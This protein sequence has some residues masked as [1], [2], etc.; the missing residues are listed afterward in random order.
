M[1][2]RIHAGW[3]QPL[4]HPG[5]TPSAL[6]V[7]IFQQLWTQAPSPGLRD[8][9][10]PEPCDEWGLSTAKL[11]P[12]SKL[13]QPQLES[14][15][16]SSLGQTTRSEKAFHIWTTFLVK[17]TKTREKPRSVNSSENS[18]MSSTA[19]LQSAQGFPLFR[20]GKRDNRRSSLQLEHLSTGSIL[21]AGSPFRKTLSVRDQLW[22]L[23]Q[24][25]FLCGTCSSGSLVAAAGEMASSL[26]GWAAWSLPHCPGHVYLSHCCTSQSIPNDICF[27]RRWNA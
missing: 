23:L 25:C 14:P 11:V 17:D 16:H 4:A 12:D 7:H 22:P 19:S 18:S 2:I 10:G 21:E 1:S 15:A 5:K 20:E 8:C 3:E 26:P 13:S 9:S 24:L 27:K 6:I